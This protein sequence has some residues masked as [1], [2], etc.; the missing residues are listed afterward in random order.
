MDFIWD[1]HVEETKNLKE[2][3]G[4]LCEG[5]LMTHFG[6]NVKYAEKLL[7]ELG[8]RHAARRSPDN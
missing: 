8:V 5:F 6:V 1:M 4:I 7:I 3:F 2:R